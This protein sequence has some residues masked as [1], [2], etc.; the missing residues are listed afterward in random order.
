MLRVLY[1]S[2]LLICLAHSVNAAGEAQC[3]MP[4]SFIDTPPPTI[5]PARLV[6]RVE[7]ITID[8]P[9]DVVMAEANRTPLEKTMHGTS[10]LPGVAGTHILRGTWPEPGAMRITCLTDGG[11]TEEQVI[12]NTRSGNTYQF[13]YEVWNYTTPRARP[14]VYGVGDFL[15]TDLGDGRTRIHWTYAFRLRPDRFPGYLGPLGR[16]LFRTF[17]LDTRYAE[18]MHGA[19]AVRKANA[20]RV[21]TPSDGALRSGRSGPSHDTEGLFLPRKSA[22]CLRYSSRSSNR[23]SG[24]ALPFPVTERW[25]ASA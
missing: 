25:P 10:T 16:L 8:R 21:P 23:F 12:A 24:F 5:E 6:N 13:R 19:L 2:V 17:Y 1:L 11:T 4:A 22:D 3:P 7:E 15:E 20:E 9:L 18:L 14:I